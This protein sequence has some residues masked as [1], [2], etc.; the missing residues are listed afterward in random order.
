MSDIQKFREVFAQTMQGLQYMRAEFE[1]L[2]GSNGNAQKPVSSAPVLNPT[3]TPQGLPPAPT[4]DQMA[5]QAKILTEQ[6]QTVA[7]PAVKNPTVPGPATPAAPKS[8]VTQ[9]P[10]KVEGT[11]VN[12]KKGGKKR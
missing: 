2:I 7:A 11:V 9:Q 8:A 1:S 5:A 4:L 10:K 6:S 12:A 3:A